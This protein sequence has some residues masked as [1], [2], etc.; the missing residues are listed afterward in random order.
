MLLHMISELEFQPNN[1]K[2]A[3]SYMYVLFSTQC[4]CVHVFVAKQPTTQSW[5][6]LDVNSTLFV[7]V[8]TISN[9]SV[10]TVTKV[11]PLHMP[12]LLVMIRTV[13]FTITTVTICST[14]F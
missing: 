14:F 11:F 9:M 13:C 1:L 12:F 6:L 7:H 5:F 3:Y 8:C 10:M 2:Y 4:T